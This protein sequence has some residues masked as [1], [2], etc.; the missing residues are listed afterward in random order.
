[1]TPAGI[2]PDFTLGLTESQEA[3]ARDYLGYA[4]S[5]DP[6]RIH[7]GVDVER[8]NCG[9]VT[10]YIVD[11][12]TDERLSEETFTPGEL[13]DFVREVGHYWYQRDRLGDAEM[14]ALNYLYLVADYADGEITK[15]EIE[16]EQDRFEDRLDG[17]DG[18]GLMSGV[19]SLQF[20][21]RTE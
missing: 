11:T 7:A 20:R 16:E 15:E 21:K 13:R 12:E 5:H 19:V 4:E 2:E 10:V 3:F 17:E 9:E 8:W 6:E 1:M 18:I 14:R